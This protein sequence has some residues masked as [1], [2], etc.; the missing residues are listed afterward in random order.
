MSGKRVG[1]MAGLCLLIGLV[2]SECSARV[3]FGPWVTKVDCS[4]ATILW[5]GT[6]DGPVGP[7][8]VEGGGSSFEPVPAS[9]PIP[10]RSELLC[11][12]RLTGLSEFTDYSY[13]VGAGVDAVEGSF[14]TASRR[15]APFRFVVYGDTRSRP[16]EH[17]RVCEGIAAERPAFVV[18]TGDLVANGDQ[19]DLW[20]REFFDPA[21]PYLAG[22]PIWPVRGNHELSAVFYGVLFARPAG[23]YYYSFDFGNVHFVVLDSSSRR[24]AEMLEWLEADL[25]SS[26]AEWTFAAYHEPTFNIGGH[27]STWGREDFL[28]VL[29][30]HGVDFVL[31]GH[32]HLYERF[33]PIGPAGMKPIVH[34]VTGG[35][36]APVYPARPSPILVG[37]IGRSELHF[38]VFE[39]EGNRCD[40]TVKRPDGTVID[41]LSLVK[42]NGLYQHE[43]MADA[44]ETQRA[45]RMAFAFRDVAVDFGR[46]P[47]PGQTVRAVLRPGAG[48]RGMELAARPPAGGSAWGVS[49]LGNGLELE[50]RAPADLKVSP[51]G[52]DPPLRLDL[53]LRE[54]ERLYVA[55]DQVIDLSDATYHLL[56]PEPKPVD[57]PRAPREITLD[58]RADDWQGLKPLPLP[59]EGGE[60]GSLY[61]CWCPRGLYG[62]LVARDESVEANSEAPWRA[63]SLEL[64]VEKDFA[65]ARRRSANSAQ[66]VFSPAPEKGPGEGHFLIAY[67]ANRGKESGARCRWRPSANGYVIELFIP[68]GMLAP[69]KMQAGTVIGLNFA[70]NDDGRP[71][72]QFYS[73]KAGDGWRSPIL[74]GAIRLKG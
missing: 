68:A 28:P 56:I 64:F 71:T 53:T 63:D 58:G 22:C 52:F 15:A 18:C 17:R 48:A 26:R 31:T 60:P 62:L 38:C 33:R 9:E 29:E 50:L 7:V 35:G 13:R 44:I 8:R 66:Y 5:V 42:S 10:G 21:A 30:R 54:G 23:R 40:M 51:D 49:V 45:E 57:I 11:S 14:R 16:E 36:G 55:R 20:K 1:L 24:K 4:S 27:G 47:A 59:F 46:I 12:A 61:L 3:L 74:W 70:L 41:R 69:A 37:G 67:G 65:R 32:S 43:V 34:I 25:S 2:C 73:D 39:V 72:Q 19:W 6:P